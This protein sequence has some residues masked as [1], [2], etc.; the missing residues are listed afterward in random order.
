MSTNRRT[1]IRQISLGALGVGIVTTFPGSLE[2]FPG[3]YLPAGRFLPRSSPEKQGISSTAIRRFLDAV[4]KS[5]L[6][7]H[8]VMLVRH[9][10]VVAEGWW[11]P[12]APELKHTLYSLSKSFTSTAVG[13]AVADGK[14]TVED[15][16]ISFFPDDLPAGMSDN[17]AA[18]KVRHLLTMNTGHAVD[19]MGSI[20]DAGHDNW[21]KAFLSVPVEHAPGSHFLY[22]TGATY[23]LSAIVQKL[24]GRTVLD[25]LSERLFKPLGIEGADWETDPKGI[26]VGGFG[27][28]VRTEDIAKFGQLYLQKGMWNGKQ[29]LPAQWVEDATKKQTTSQ[30]GDNDWSQGYGYQFWRCK[31]EPGFYRGDGAFGQFCIVIP[32]MDAV[33]AITAESFDLQRSMTLVWEN[34]LPAMQ[35]GRLPK[36]KAEHNLLKADLEKLALKPL[37]VIMNS[38]MA[39]GISGKSYKLA[40]NDWGLESIVFQLNG[41][42]CRVTL[43]GAGSSQTIDCGLGRWVAAGNEKKEKGLFS[44]PFRTSVPTKIAACAAWQNENTLALQWKYIENVH[45]DL[46]TCVFDGDQV[47]ISLLSSMAAGNKVADGRKALSGKAG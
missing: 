2:A 27:L 21:A 18:M 45:G 44:L 36:N 40:P 7:F 32:Q 30:G 39:A 43:T 19:T 42:N 31:P 37:P 29:L 6:E 14:L 4:D 5:G 35:E 15:P 25:F 26:S 12:F 23:M 11:S 47:T 10:H 13:M 24:T 1:F 22:N 17:L 3:Q 9:G 34:L 20:R 8:S 33:V 41:N 28:R 38:S 46:L 16:V